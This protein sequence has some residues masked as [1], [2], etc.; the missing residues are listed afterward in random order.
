MDNKKE[1]LQKSQERIKQLVEEFESQQEFADYCGIS[2]YSLS[3][4]VNG[5]N[6]PGNMNAAKIAKKLLLNPL[7]IMGFDVPMRSQED[8]ER[9]NRYEQGANALR[10]KM[11]EHFSHRSALE[12]S[13]DEWDLITAFR[14]LNEAGQAK[15]LGDVADMT[16]IEKYKKDKKENGFI[17]F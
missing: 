17:R 15:A 1:L 4:Y 2:K 6:A 11:D 7:W 14:M 12:I 9:I 5:T 3:Q 16:F 10:E 8:A 13:D